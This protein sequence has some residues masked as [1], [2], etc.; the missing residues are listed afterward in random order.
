MDSTKFDNV[1]PRFSETVYLVEA[2][3]YEALSLWGEHAQN[4]GYFNKRFP[5][6]RPVVWEQL[7]NGFWLQVGELDHRPVCVNFFWSKLNGKLVCF[8]DACS[9]VVDH[10]MIEHWFD[11]NLAGI[12]RTDAMNFGHVL[13]AVTL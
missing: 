10:R 7:Y 4:T 2:N 12:P 8:W 1:D 6:A 5:D 3:S 9:Q 11:T 13:G